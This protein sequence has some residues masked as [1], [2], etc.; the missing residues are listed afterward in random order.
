MRKPKIKI[1]KSIYRRNKVSASKRKIS[2]DEFEITPLVKSLIGVIK[3][4][5]DYDYKKD[6][7][8]YLLKKYESLI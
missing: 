3:L 6:Y 8:E 7:V 2:I 1:Y 5:K 4:P